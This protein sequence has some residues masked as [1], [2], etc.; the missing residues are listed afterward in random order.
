VDV[1]GVTPTIGFSRKV[2]YD[3]A[4]RALVTTDASGATVQTEWN[5]KDQATATVD[6][7]GRRSTTVY[8]YADRPIDHYGPAPASCFNG[9]FPTSACA[10]TVPHSHTNYDEGFVGLSSAYY[11]NV[12]L[13]GAPKVYATGVGTTD[14]TL[15]QNW[16]ASPPVANTNGWSGRFTGEIQFP[17]AGTYGVG[18]NV[19]DGVRLW[20]DDVLVIDSWTDKPTNTSV[21]GSYNNITAGAWHR[22]RVDYY[23]RNGTTGALNFTW[24]PP[25]TQPSVVVPGQYLH[26]RYGLATSA[27]ESESESNAVPDKTGA[28]KYGENGLDPTYGLATSAAANPAGLNLTGRAGYETPGSGYLRRTSKTMPTGSSYS[29]V[30]YGDTETRAN[31]CVTGSPLVNQGGLQK[32]T[33][34]PTPATGAARTDELVYDASGRAVAKAISGD[35]ICTTYDAR[36]RPTQV[37]YPANATTG[38]RTVTDNYAVAGDPLTTSLSDGAGTVTT[39]VDLLGRVTSYTDVQGT[40]TTTTYDQAGRVTQEVVTPPNAAD[41]AQT[42]AHTYDDAGRVLTTKL[43]TTTLA[44]TSYDTAGELASVS[45]ANGSSLA[46]IGKD[47]AGRVTSLTWKT[48][49]AKQ[50]VSAVSR[51]QA[52]TVYKETLGG[53][54]PN[55]TGPSYVYDAAGRLTEAYATGHHFTYDFTSTADAAC[56]TGTQPNAGMNTNRV[57]LLDQTTAGTAT[58]SY[59]YDAADRLIATTGATAIT[60]I[61]YDSHGNTTAFTSGGATTN[62][63]FDSSDRNLTAST[64]SADPTQVASIAYVRD[65]TNRIVTRGASAGD[66]QG[67]VLYGYTTGGDSASLTFGAD[68]R[69]LTRSLP[70]PGGVLLT[71][72][73]PGGVAT[74]EYDHVTIRGDICLSTDST[75]KQVGTLYSYDPYG[76]PLRADGTPDPQAVPTNQP[77]K[78]NYGWLGQHQRPYEHAGALSLVQMGARPYS[79]LLGR[80]LSVDPVEG[81]SANDYDYVKADPINNVDLQGLYS[82]NYSYY[83]GWAWSSADTIFS[84]VKRWFSYLFPVSGGCKYLIAGRSCTLS[85]GNPVRITQVGSR[86]FQLLSLPGH[87]EGPWKTINFTLRKNRWGV[88]YL[89]VWA[90]GPDNT[91]CNRSWL[92]SWA[93][94]QAANLLWTYF[95]RTINLVAW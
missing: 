90:R 22:V 10:A 18:F 67:T 17:A 31:P 89:D 95:S 23:N 35:W 5:V 45:Y 30:H 43:G 80:F 88:V 56:P 55:P 39:K 73:Y 76:R 70:L 71:F 68:K 40:I 84:R 65:A 42:T 60:G 61:T 36:D 25:V 38:A 33:T 29:Y 8:D 77:G 75:G 83:V 9:Q 74:P 58:T 26:P 94:R 37:L 51:T 54:D 28:V 24:S 46:A 4:D 87:S 86:H 44:T 34:S 47:S 85:G 53:V 66:P 19:V 41:A 16:G 20:I 14:G 81:G 82:Y 63:G 93:N 15:S 21:P 32:L 3:D 91:W 69:L 49:D 50:I 7:A 27:T 92:C 1:A 13:A 79:P 57:R 2:T 11:D 64:T 12:A 62:L 48:S 52:G 78:L 6:A 72:T 59:C